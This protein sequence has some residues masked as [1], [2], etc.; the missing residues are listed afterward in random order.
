MSARI[1]LKADEKRLLA[2]LAAAGAFLAAA[3]PA[4]A[5]VVYGVVDSGTVGINSGISVPIGGASFYFFNTVIPNSGKV[6]HYGMLYSVKKGALKVNSTF[7]TSAVNFPKKELVGPGGT[8]GTYGILFRHIVYDTGKTANAGKFGPSGGYLGIIINP[9]LGITYYGW[10][11]IDSVAA[12]FSSYHIAD[13]A[14]QDDGTP[15][16][17]GYT[18]PEP[19]SSALALIAMGAAGLAIYRKRKQDA[20]G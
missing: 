14:Y 9:S 13:W 7:L 20:Q 2:Y 17:A 3:G 18:V 4:D 16:A 6:S 19:T 5:S 1:T 10:L 15:I 8:L 11:H 12:D